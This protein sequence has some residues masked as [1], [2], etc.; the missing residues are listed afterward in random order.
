MALQKGCASPVLI[1]CEKILLFSE[2]KKV[3]G[4]LNCSGRKKDAVQ[5]TG[6]VV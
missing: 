4:T 1:T 2:K 3:S 5:E 6:E